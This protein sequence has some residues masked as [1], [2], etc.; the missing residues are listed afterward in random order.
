MTAYQQ[1]ATTTYGRQ[2][3]FIKNVQTNT[4]PQE[5]FLNLSDHNQVWTRLFTTS[6]SS[7]AD[8]NAAVNT[9][10]YRLTWLYRTYSE[11]YP[12]N[13]VIQRGILQNFLA[14]DMQFAVTAVQ[15][16]NYKDTSGAKHQLP[17][18]MRTTA[19]G[20]HSIQRFVAQPWAV[21]TFIISGSIITILCVLGFVWILVQ[22]SPIP[23][24]TGITEWDVLGRT[25]GGASA[26]HPDTVPFDALFHELPPEDRWST[27]KVSR[28]L[29]GRRLKLVEPTHVGTM[30]RH[31][32]ERTLVVV[33]D[34]IE[35]KDTTDAEAGFCS[36]A[37]TFA[38]PDISPQIKGSSSST[39][40]ELPE[41]DLETT[42]EL[43]ETGTA[44]VPG[45]EEDEKSTVPADEE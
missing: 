14:I 12:D 25:S 21:L 43:G 13:D 17:D 27:W 29:R 34:V 5:L 45:V 23:E 8:A 3:L 39:D 18:F 26:E 24:S 6:I 44:M 32:A 9:I 41:L 10:L 15:Y 38:K 31:Q 28:A 7:T 37:T 40:M 20:G 2:D 42:V 22:E 33:R 30:N 19:V 4:D 11:W 16:A 35:A 36:R 1:M